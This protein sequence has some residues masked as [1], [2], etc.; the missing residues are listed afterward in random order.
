MQLVFPILNGS[1][2][3]RQGEVNRWSTRTIFSCF[4]LGGVVMTTGTGTQSGEFVLP[5]HEVERLVIPSVE[6]GFEYEVLLGGPPPGLIEPS[7]PIPLL[8]VLDGYLTGLSAIEIARLMMAVGEIE[9]IAIAAV[10]PNGGFEVGNTRRLRDFSSDAEIDLA[11]HPYMKNFLPRFEAMGVEPK[12]A[13]GGSDAFRRFLVNELLPAV[14]ARSPIDRERL[15]LFGHSAGGSFLIEALL[16]GDTPFS[17]YLIGEAGTFLLLGTD[18]A[19]L[20]KGLANRPL[21]AQRAFYADSSDT[22]KA[23][24]EMIEQSRAIVRRINEEVGVPVTMVSYENETHTTMMPGF[25]KDGLLFLYGTGKTYG[26]S[27]RSLLNPD[28]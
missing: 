20:A 3:N 23:A 28:S 21:P 22:R 9:P 7:Q 24:P 5:N 19:L 2:R 15:G 8:V 10:S 25:I 16:E 27:M 4:L 1:I 12:D 26:D 17:D 13:V 6:A 14:G 18:E 11:T